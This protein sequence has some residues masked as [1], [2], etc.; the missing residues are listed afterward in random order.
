MLK[1][2]VEK[3]GSMCEQMENFSIETKTTKKGPNGNA[4]YKK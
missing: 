1:D 3:V 2:V 4:R